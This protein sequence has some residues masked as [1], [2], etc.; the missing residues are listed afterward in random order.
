[1]AG[2]EGFYPYPHPAS[3][4]SAAGVLRDPPNATLATRDHPHPSSPKCDD[5]KRLII[6]LTLNCRIW[7]RCRR[8]RGWEVPRSRNK[9]DHGFVKHTCTVVDP[10]RGRSMCPV[11]EVLSVAKEQRSGRR[12]GDPAVRA[13]ALCIP[14]FWNLLPGISIAQEYL[15]NQLKS[16]QRDVP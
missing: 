9:S 6:S 5:K 15:P 12:R 13:L 16:L 1:L 7:G 14:S 10:R 4:R 2:M 3:L 11:A 8:R